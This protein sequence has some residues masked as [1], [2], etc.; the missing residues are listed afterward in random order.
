[1]KL[2]KKRTADRATRHQRDGRSAMMNEQL[3][4]NIEA[5][6]EK[7]TCSVKFFVEKHGHKGHDIS[8]S[9]RDCQTSGGVAD[10]RPLAQWMAHVEHQSH[11]CRETNQ[12]AV[13]MCT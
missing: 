5:G 7:E 2:R 3:A 11:F 10:A 6:N 12:T 1:M 9:C 8:T 4:T 13:Q